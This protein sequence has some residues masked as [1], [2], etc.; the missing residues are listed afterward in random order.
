MIQLNP[1]HNYRKIYFIISSM[2]FWWCANKNAKK[3]SLKELY[4]THHGTNDAVFLIMRAKYLPAR[5]TT[6]SYEKTEYWKTYQYT[7]MCLVIIRRMHVVKP[8]LASS[9]PKIWKVNI[10]F[11]IFTF[12]ARIILGQWKIQFFSYT[13]LLIF[14]FFFLAAW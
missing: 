12:L 8:L 7:S 14:F 11:L 2:K 9:I 4:L 1:Y 3:I 10:L 13:V 5:M 6:L